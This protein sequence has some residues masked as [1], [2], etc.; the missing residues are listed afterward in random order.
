MES[1]ILAIGTMKVGIQLER[2]VGPMK[3]IVHNALNPGLGRR[4]HRPA[5]WPR[6]FAG[7]VR[8][9]LN[10]SW[11]YCGTMGMSLKN[12]QIAMPINAY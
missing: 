11:R 10:P 7:Q 3:T 9:R 1:I 4:I 5:Q 12:W 6:L 2:W 8:L